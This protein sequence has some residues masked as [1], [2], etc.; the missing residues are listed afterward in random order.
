MNAKM[1][2]LNDGKRRAFII[3]AVVELAACPSIKSEDDDSASAY[4]S[5]CCRAKIKKWERGIPRNPKFLM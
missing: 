3:A 4:K 2:L 1:L 5:D